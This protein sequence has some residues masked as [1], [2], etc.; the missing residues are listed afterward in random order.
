MRHLSV[1]RLPAEQWR[2]GIASLGDKNEPPPTDEQIVVWEYAVRLLAERRAG[3]TPASRNVEEYPGAGRAEKVEAM[4][5]A[6]MAEY[7]EVTQAKAD[8]ERHFE[9]PKVM[10]EALADLRA[11]RRRASDSLWVE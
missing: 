2:Y 5:A 1:V 4:I 8:A 6:D 11:M 9:D 10:E 3:R 7:D